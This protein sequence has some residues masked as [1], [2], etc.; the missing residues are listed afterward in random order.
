MKDEKHLV[1]LPRVRQ[2][3]LTHLL[4][5]RSQ[6]EARKPGLQHNMDLNAKTLTLLLEKN[7][8]ADQPAHPR[9]LLSAVLI[10]YLKT[11]SYMIYINSPFLVG[12]NMIKPLATPLY[13]LSLNI[14]TTPF[15]CLDQNRCYKIMSFMVKF[16]LIM[17]NYPPPPPYQH[18]SP[19]GLN[20]NMLKLQNK[21]IYRHERKKC[22]LVCLDHHQ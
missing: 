7:N 4:Q 6:A 17:S 13:S 2:R 5:A 21:P 22:H 15:V 20:R 16:W 11:R 8:G 14:Y 19:V 9:R 1:Y 18:P 12:F 3:T 10:R